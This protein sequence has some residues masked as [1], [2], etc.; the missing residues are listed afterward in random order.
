MMT[1][2]LV[3]TPNPNVIVGT[4]GGLVIRSD[5]Q[6]QVPWPLFG[7]MQRASLDRGTKPAIAVS[8]LL[9]EANCV[10]QISVTSQ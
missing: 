7:Q 2:T 10:D 5:A 6:L 3:R 4:E 1:K 9:L 8:S